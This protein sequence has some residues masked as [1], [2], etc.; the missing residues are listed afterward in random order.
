MYASRALAE[1]LPG[2]GVLVL[3]TELRIM[4]AEG[5]LFAR[6]GVD[7][8]AL[9]GTTLPDWAGPE[10]WAGSPRY[11]A[12]LAGEAQS[13][14]RWES[15]GKVYW[16]QITPVRN[17][18]GVVTSLL[19]VFQ[20]VTEEAHARRRSHASR[21]ACARPSGWSASAASSATW[22]AP[23]AHVLAG[24]RSPTRRFR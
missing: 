9:E 7:V 13:F 20:E 16:L 8:R 11:A 23:A 4:Y 5:N 3:D 6:V 12:A 17:E 2:A 10:R 1:S 14:E 24:V 19:A 22:A 21:R 18:D 15:T